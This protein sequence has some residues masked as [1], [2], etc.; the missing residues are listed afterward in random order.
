MAQE[1]MIKSG[2][3]IIQ[4]LEQS[5]ST[6]IDAFLNGVAVLPNFRVHIYNQDKKS[7][8][9]EDGG[10]GSDNDNTS[11]V[12]NTQIEQV[13]KGGIYRGEHEPG[14][15]VIGLPF[16]KNNKSY[17]LFISPELNRSLAEVRYMLLTVLIIVLVVGSLLILLAARYIVKPM[18]QLTEATRQMAKGDFQI[19]IHSKRRD[20]IGVLTAS[21]NEMAGELHMLDQMRRD[22]VNNV[23]HEIQSPLASITGFTKALK[24]KQMDEVSRQRYLTIIEEES[25]RLS[26][27]STNLLRLSTLQ[28][29]QHPLHPHPFQLAEQL[30]RTVIASE[31]QWS[32]KKMEMIL[33]LEEVIINGDEDQLS[34]VWI[35]L[36]SNS[37]KFS[38]EHT[39]IAISLTATEKMVIVTIEDNGQGIPDEELHQ[40]WIPFYKVD[41]SRD[42]RVKGS[43]LGL[44]IVKRI[45]DI[46]QGDIQINSQLG[47][48]TLITIKLPIM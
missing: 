21:F 48:G 8:Y 39:S 18:R 14:S 10:S 38:P 22:F 26:R 5:K 37:I 11:Q 17:A 27:I 7:V 3:R 30:R 42:N 31:P 33:N 47:Q 6:N 29:E 46:H 12:S 20:E 44:S 25:Q 40:I 34:Q 9:Y 19:N 15:F 4:S 1:N 35:N 41:K 16:K 43:G 32:M 45:I 2:K 23:S 24:E 36:L 28:I 13:L